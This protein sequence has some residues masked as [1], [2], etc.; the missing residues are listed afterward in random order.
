MLKN[1]FVNRASVRRIRESFRLTLAWR[2][3]YYGPRLEVS[4][5]PMS[6]QVGTHFTVG[7]DDNGDFTFALSAWAFST[8]I[9]LWDVVPESV[10]SRSRARAKERAERLTVQQRRRVYAYEVDPW[11]G[12][13]TGI[14]FHHGAIWLAFWNSDNGWSRDD[15]RRW[16]WDGNGWTWSIH[17]IDLLFGEQKYSGKIGSVEEPVKVRMPEGDY[18][19]TCTTY[20]CQWSRQWW[21]GPMYWR[22]EIEIPAGVPHPGRGDSAWNCDEDATFSVTSAVSTTWRPTRQAVLDLEL[23]VLRRRGGVTWRPAKKEPSTPSTS[24]VL[25]MD[26]VR[27]GVA[28]EDATIDDIVGSKAELARAM[29]DVELVS[30]EGQ[31]RVLK[32]QDPV[33]G[34]RWAVPA[35]GDL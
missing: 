1:F 32:G 16:P 26:S 8:Y 28:F 2:D 30:P 13:R 11:E 5:F 12:R 10:R 9:S 21:S 19:A 35:E 6:R 33:E 4:L 14:D 34:G 7:G 24:V 27:E 22:T 23:E 25:G 17:P 31:L 15:R 20:Q 29:S 18:D 3:L